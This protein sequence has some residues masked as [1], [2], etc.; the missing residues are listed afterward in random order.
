M[1]L[2]FYMSQ[3]ALLQMWHQITDSSTQSTN[4]KQSEMENFN[5]IDLI[6]KQQQN[7]SKRIAKKKNITMS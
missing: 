2:Q 5:V 3:H 1:P 6:D 4:Q 7:I